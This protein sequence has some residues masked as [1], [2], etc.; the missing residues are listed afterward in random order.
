MEQLEWDRLDKKALS[1][2]QLCRTNNVL[3]EVL[4][5]K[6]IYTLWKKLETFYAT[7]YLTNRLVLKRWL[8][9]FRMNECEHLRGHLLS[10][11]KLN[12]E[13]GLD[14]KSD[15]QASIFVASRKR[16]NR[17]HYCKKLGH[18]K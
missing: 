18:I 4:I 2:I 3:H 17:C 6:T 16:D 10:K 8:Y 11:D 14:K 13:F 1:S 12:N 7:E 5:E 9:T 15:R